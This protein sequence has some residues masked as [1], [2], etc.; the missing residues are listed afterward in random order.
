MP[1]IWNWVKGWIDPV[2]ASKIQ[3]LNPADVLTTLTSHIEIANVPKRYGGELDFECGMLPDLD[4]IIKE[5]LGGKQYPP[6]P[7]K[8]IQGE[9]GDRIAV[10]V[11]S[12]N[13][14]KRYDRLSTVKSRQLESLHAGSAED[15][16]FGDEKEGLSGGIKSAGEVPAVA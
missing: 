10:A 9:G 11:G 3:Y 4:P 5:M 12:A 16:T 2:T 14:R 1:T 8:W 13:G 6:G 7:V 15:G